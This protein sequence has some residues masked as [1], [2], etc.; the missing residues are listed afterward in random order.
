[1]SK[2]CKI[3]GAE[4]VEGKC[5]NGEHL[6]KMCLNCVSCEEQDGVLYCKNEENFAAALAKVKEAIP[7][8][9]EFETLSLKPIALKDPCK[10]CKKWS[11]D[12][13]GVLEAL[14]N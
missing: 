1:M 9:Y 6:K 13:Q 10:K 2:Y 7:S 4:L 12:N 5:P 3:C 8:G 14:I 11:I